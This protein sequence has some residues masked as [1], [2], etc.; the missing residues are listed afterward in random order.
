MKI[1]GLDKKE[2]SWNV[3]KYKAKENCSKLHARARI[4]LTKQFPYDTICEE[5]TLPGSK[6]E[7]Q[8]RPLY[9]D[10]FIPQRKL[11]IEVQGE[12]HYKFNTHFFNNKIEFFKAQARDRIKIEWCD[13]NDIYLVQLPYHES[14]KEWA[15]R[16][17]NRI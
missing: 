4:F 3:T 13:I 16:I 9:A 2:Y 7:R 8:I 5:L 1:I 10:F 11:M 15:M 6:C 17:R 14:N 12:Q